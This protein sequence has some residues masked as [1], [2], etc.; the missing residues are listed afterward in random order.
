MRTFHVHLLS[1]ADTES[2]SNQLA[3]LMHIQ[4]RR[5]L[6]DLVVAYFKR[7]Q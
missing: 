4:Y 2:Y 6:I 3:T 7:S 5:Q 1:Q